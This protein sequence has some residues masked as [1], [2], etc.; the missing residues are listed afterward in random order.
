MD[1]TPPFASDVAVA[2]RTFD[3]ALILI[4]VLLLL[5]APSSAT[6]A[7]NGPDEPLPITPVIGL[8]PS[9]LDFAPCLLPGEC[10]SLAFELFN[11]VN[12]PQSMLEIVAL[13][14]QGVQFTLSG[15]LTP[16]FSIPGD[17]TRVA[18]TVEFCADGIPANGVIIVLAANAPNSPSYVHLYGNGNLPPL[19]DAGGP[20][21]G[22]TGRAIN[23]DGSR[24]GDPN[25]GRIISYAWDFGDGGTGDAAHYLHVYTAPGTYTVTL[26][27]T[28]DCGVAASCAT[29][30]VVTTGQPPICD[31]GGPYSGQVG[32]PIQFDGTGSHDP[33]GSIVLYTW[34]FGDGTGTTGPT[35]VH[36]YSGNPRDVLVRLTVRDD[37]WFSSTCTTLVTLNAAGYPVCDAGG[38]YA[39]GIGTPIQFD[40]TGS[41][42]PDGTIVAYAWEFGDGATGTGPAP[43]HTYANA[44]AYSVQLSVVDNVGHVSTCQTGASVTMS[45]EPPIC[46]AGGPYVGVVG[47][48][49]LFDGSASY[50]P[51]GTIASYA[52]Q[53]GDGATG[54]GVRPGHVYSSPGTYPVELCVTDDRGARSCCNSTAIIN[55]SGAPL[56]PVIGVRP[57]ELDFGN[58]TPVGGTSDYM[59]QV[60]NDVFDPQSILHLTAAD[61]A[62]TAFSLAAGP[63]LPIDI[64]GDG[65]EVT[66]TV[67]FTAVGGQS[68]GTTTFTA[69]GAVNTPLAV[70]LS[71]RGNSPPLCDAGDPY[72]GI[73][74]TALRFDGTASQDPEGFVLSYGWDFGD[75]GQGV[76]PTPEHVYTMHGTFIVALR[77]IDDC[78]IF[79][80]CTSTAIVRAA[81]VCDAGG[82]YLGFPGQPVQFDGT[83]SHD[84]DGVIVV[85]AWDFGD[86]ASGSGPTPT[87]TYLSGGPF[88]VTLAVTDDDTLTSQC[89]TIVHSG[90]TPVTGVHGFAA[91]LTGTGIEL[92]W[93]VR[94][95]AEFAGFEIRRGRDDPPE[96]PHTI[97]ELVLDDDADGR[98]VW[99]DLRTEPGASY[100][101]ELVAIGRGGGRELVATLSV[102]LPALS[103]VLHAPYPQ[104]VASLPAT[105]P[106]DLPR[107]AHVNVRV[108]GAGGRVVRAL[109][110]ADLGPGRH[111]VI[112]DGA[113][114]NGGPVPAGVYLVVLESRGELRRE[115]IVIVR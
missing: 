16:P 81:P 36:T 1:R 77:V 61:V 113:N 41:Y 47:A 17:G 59:I 40:G 42:D 108:V 14:C 20:Y 92:S 95:P 50:D 8:D 60:R 101:Y 112:W 98:Y 73:T 4:L 12:D 70:P 58:C 30:A 44:G 46:A 65:S 32:T 91:D 67:R 10:D 15:G 63:P 102:R 97:A 94:D 88:F 103:F 69:P 68:T 28:D 9:N 93:L 82:P 76:G 38:P 31:T 105:I 7:P 5:L 79:A 18:F 45:N 39:G 100:G 25:G 90:A 26:R 6:A 72:A 96:P 66:F 99:T 89:E 57:T 43:T 80:D 11:A 107:A 51:D 62:G 74:G 19:C 71:G 48:S 2:A 85:Y 64:R 56:T 22:F 114:G 54:S 35:P 13:Q 52:W 55:P 109:L 86:G 29:S 24:S 84:P 23:F 106:F 33:D 3:S 53:F 87:H 111:V 83:G 78:A 37:D 75:G 34:D 104:P 110:A 27:V 115:K 21:E 49:I